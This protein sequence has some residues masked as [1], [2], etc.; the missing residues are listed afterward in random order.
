MGD[1]PGPK[2]RPPALGLAVS[3]AA[4]IRRRTA[5]IAE[6]ADHGR[7]AQGPFTTR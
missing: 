4:G 5:L 7:L 3:N 6:L 2:T 1:A